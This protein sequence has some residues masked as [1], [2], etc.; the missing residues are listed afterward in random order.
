MACE[1]AKQFRD[2]FCPCIRLFLIVRIAMGTVQQPQRAKLLQP[3]IQIPPEAAEQIVVGVPEGKHGI[4]QVLEQWCILCLEGLVKAVAVVRRIS[5]SE[6]AG[7]E[8]RK[9]GFCQIAYGILVHIYQPYV[10]TGL[11]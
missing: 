7:D 9:P 3:S 11:L 5:G 6:G 2:I 10:V 8:Q 4:M 1:P